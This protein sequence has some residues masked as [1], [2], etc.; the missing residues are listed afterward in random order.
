MENKNNLLERISKLIKE[1]R[2]LKE[3][4]ETCNKTIDNLSEKNEKLE[5]RK[6]SDNKID[7]KHYKMVTVLI[8][9]FFGFST[10]ANK[11]DSTKLIDELDDIYFNLKKISKKHNVEKIRTIGDAYMCVGGVP[12]KNTT[13]SIDIVLAAL[14][15]QEYI[16]KIQQKH[17]KKGEEFWSF[18]MGI[19]TGS[20]TAINS[21]SKNYTLKGETVDITSRVKSIAYKGEINI[22]AMT[23]EL[24]KEYFTCKY[25]SLLPIKYK[26]DYE[27]YNVTKIK[28]AYS[29]NR[30]GRFPNNIFNTKYKLRQLA[31]LQEIILDKLEKELPKYLYYHNVKHT[32]DVITQVELIGVVEGVTDYELLLLKTAALFHDIGQIHQSKGHEAIG[33]EYT[34]KILPKYGYS[35]DEIDE[36]NSIIMATELPPKPKN[37]LQKIICDAD[38][39]Y[40][41]R[42]DFIPVSDTLFKELKEQG[43]VTD[44]NTWNKMQI[45]F[46]ESHHYF[47]DTANKL[48]QV[49]KQEQIDRLKHLQN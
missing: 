17:Q 38:L 40:L 16:K 28:K 33:C 13:N 1:N 21:G 39:D 32:I 15:M 37:L 27:V 11:H 46:L 23:Y 41:G 3:Q 18:K 8:V 22:S 48:R 31:D 47:T 4:I 30:E 34:K 7:I 5:L 19:H 25:K 14:E 44:I 49:N 29:I 35:N 36:I 6:T 9:E 2:S 45:S 26:K 42:S 43:I 12:N 24:V 10:I 20:V